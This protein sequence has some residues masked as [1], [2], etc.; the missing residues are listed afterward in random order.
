MSTEYTIFKRGDKY[1]LA[2]EHSSKVN[3]WMSTGLGNDESY[4]GQLRNLETVDLV[5]IALEII[6][7]AAY[8]GDLTGKC[9]EYL[10]DKPDSAFYYQS[11]M[12]AVGTER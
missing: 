9:E 10:E 2:E 8:T 11:M 4:D 12:K 7:V 6:K 5:G 1:L 3:L